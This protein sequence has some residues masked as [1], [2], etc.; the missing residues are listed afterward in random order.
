[1]VDGRSWLLIPQGKIGFLLE[2]LW[3]TWWQEGGSK[4]YSVGDRVAALHFPRR[5]WRRGLFVMGL[6]APTSDATVA[7]RHFLR[8]QATQVAGLAHATS[9]K[10]LLGDFNAEMGTHTPPHQPGSSV[11]GQFGDTRV[12]IPG[13]EWRAWAEREGY[14][15]AQSQYS[16]RSRW[17]WS[18]P[19]F[20]STH[21]LDHVWV[22]AA[23]RWHLTQCRTLLEGP[24]V[25]WPWSDYTDHNPVEAHFRHGKIWDEISTVCWVS[26][27]SFRIPHPP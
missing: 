16:H 25:T 8:T 23:S 11:M 19:R 3:A 24:S 9:L 6:Y 12:T 7:D 1:M 15:H 14:C 26:C 2:D 22:D 20:H 13:L 27:I 5:G 4:V 17:T 21:E 10:V 18:H